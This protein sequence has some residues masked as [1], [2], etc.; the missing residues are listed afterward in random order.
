MIKR[1]ALVMAV[2]LAAACGGGG[3]GDD[4][5]P[6]D[7]PPGGGNDVVVEIHKS[8]PFVDGDTADEA[9]FV[10]VQ[11]G[12]GAF[13][14]AS[15]TNGVY[16]V[17]ITNDRFGVAVGCNDQ[18]QAFVDIE[19][20]QQT[21]E[22]GLLY[23]TICKT[24]PTNATL[25]VAVSKLPTGSR[26]RLRTP[27]NIGVATSDGTVSIDVPAGPTEMF[28]TLTDVNKNVL[29]MFRNQIQVAGTTNL[30]LD[31]AVDG[32]PPDL[33]GT[34]TVSPNDDTANFQTSVIRPYGVVGVL[35]NLGAIGTNRNYVM[36]PAALRLADDSYR[37]TVNGST[38]TASK[39]AKT[40]G[41][42]A[43]TLPAQ[44][45]APPSELL[46]TPFLHPVWTFSPTASTLAN[47]SYFM[48][49]S[50][51]GDFS[52]P[53]FRDWFVTISAKWVA[54]Q[55]TVRYEFPD[56]TAMTGYNE[57]VLVTRERIDTTIERT[58]FSADFAVDGAESTSS[59]VFNTVGE[60]CGDDVVQNPPEMCDPGALGETDTCDSDC[61]PVSCGDNVINV[62]AGEDCDPPDGA[63]CD[64]QCHAI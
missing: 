50:N 11:D 39:T 4:Q 17:H 14:E 47:Q 60:F 62:T 49:A 10:A 16:T 12:D 41:A 63:T 54:G 59:S 24:R 55:T 5:P 42:L 40:P 34:F 27:L 32:A 57:L 28:G 44:F 18:N 25:D 58:D 1:W 52:A 35:G 36:L 6:P 20:I 38:G 61:T 48:D 15:G 51:F 13:V 45:T 53:V 33:T 46:T 9:N 30:A 8:F 31:A 26:L 43:F 21:V 3:N 19:I 56:L 64:A 7:G 37:F 2:T 22:D 23:R 29:R